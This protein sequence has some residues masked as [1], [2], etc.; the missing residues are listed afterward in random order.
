MEN[1]KSKDAHKHCQ[2]PSPLSCKW[3]QLY[4]IKAWVIVYSIYVCLHWTEQQVA[5][6]VHF[7]K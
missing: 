3:I 2:N 5:E 7:S 1:S 6:S 4:S